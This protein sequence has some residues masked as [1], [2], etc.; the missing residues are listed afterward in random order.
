MLDEEAVLVGDD[1]SFLVCDRTRF[2]GITE[3]ASVPWLQMSR[4]FHVV[5]MVLISAKT[6]LQ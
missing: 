4:G 3:A 2:L 5:W 1:C 6:Q